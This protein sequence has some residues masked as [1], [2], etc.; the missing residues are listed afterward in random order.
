MPVEHNTPEGRRKLAAAGSG[1]KNNESFDAAMA[2]MP[3][4][5]NPRSVW[6]IPTQPYKGSHFATFPEALVERCILA[7]SR[8]G[9][10]VFDP[11][12]GSG[13]VARVAHRLGRRYLGC[14]LNPK[15]ASLHQGRLEGQTAGIGL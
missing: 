4:H 11:F 7:G 3:T 13:T 2:V 6:T 9:D 12:M 14:E 10:V 15:Y 1:T 5:R 8:P